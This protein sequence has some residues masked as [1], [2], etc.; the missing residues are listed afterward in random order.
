[1]K[2]FRLPVFAALGLLTA[3][4]SAAGTTL[5]EQNKQIIA[6]AVKDQ[7]KDPDSAKFKWPAPLK[8]G[9]YCGWVNAKNSYGGYTGFQ[10][11]M[12]IGGVGTGSKSDGK[13][14]IVGDVTIGSGDDDLMIV[15]KM[16]SEHG[17]SMEEPPTG[18]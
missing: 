8:F 4:A 13:F 10:P 3:Q 17:F 9:L 6:R 1:M 14:L 18:G 5:S 11:Y 2:R 15:Y 12:V 16:C 7:L